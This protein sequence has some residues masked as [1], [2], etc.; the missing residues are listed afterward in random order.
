MPLG[1]I[2]LGLYLGQQ[3]PKKASETL[4]KALQSARNQAGR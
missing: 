4:L 3:S 2:H 1:R